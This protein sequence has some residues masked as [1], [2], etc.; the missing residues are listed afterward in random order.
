MAEHKAIRSRRIKLPFQSVGK[1]DYIF[2]SY[3][4]NDKDRVYPILKELFEAGYNIWYDEGITIGEHYDEEI[5][6][7]IRNSVAVIYFVSEWS[8]ARPYIT[9]TELPV[10]RENTRR[11][12]LPLCLEDAVDEPEKIT[13]ILPRERYDSVCEIISRLEAL[14]VKNYGKRIAVPI[15][16]DVPLYWLEGHDLEPTGGTENAVFT[17][18]APYACLSFDARDLPACNPYAKE[19]YFAGYNVRSC[20]NENAQNIAAMIS[21]TECNA[22]MPFVTKNYIESGQLE[23]DYNTAKAAGKRLVA[24]YMEPGIV[25]SLPGSIADEFSSY[26]GLNEDELRA[27]DFLSKLETELETRGCCVLNENGKVERR[28]FALRDYLY[29]F[30]PDRRGIVLTKYKGAETDVVI[31]KSYYGFPSVKL[32][33]TFSHNSDVV[34]VR[35]PFTV[36]EIIDKAFGECRNLKDVYV[37]DSVT[38]ISLDSFG[39]E[40]T[41]RPVY[42]V[43]HCSKRSFAYY[44]A[45]RFSAYYYDLYDSRSDQY[46]NCIQELDI[47]IETDLGICADGMSTDN[48][49]APEYIFHKEADGGITLT[50]YLG[51]ESHVVVPEELEGFPVTGIGSMTFC[52]SSK[53]T[54]VTLPDSIKSIADYAFHGCSSLTSVKLPA[55]VT[56]IA[57]HG[58]WDCTGLI[59]VTIPGSVKSIGDYAFKGC[60]SLTSV[61]LP[62]GVTDIGD[63]AF[64]GCRSLSAVS[65]PESVTRIGKKAFSWCER[66]TSAVIPDSVTNIGEETF[67]WCKSLLSVTIPGSVTSIG[68]KV[69]AGCTDALTVLCPQNSEAWRYCRGKKIPH[70][71]KRGDSAIKIVRILILFAVLLLLGLILIRPSF[72]SF[73]FKKNM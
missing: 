4:H 3:G 61:R 35:V 5:I 57:D 31:K 26:Q 2:A 51:E 69:F 28:S 6:R 22:F 13:A 70:R 12:I 48:V 40:S 46:V 62:D 53:L 67:S 42:C 24:L 52:K 65:L 63:G 32:D 41:E 29:D 33:H 1:G 59:S 54:S 56:S 10:A 16:R 50:A 19:L 66:L 7:S 36:N 34:S 8:V 11:A 27:N 49:H 58:F 44:Y 9:E 17:E 72:L 73:L 37:P 43:V 14:G 47:K 39:Y 25:R 60:S 64:F 20:E 30:T 71:R 21:S 68:R 15:E 38:H 55:G 45:K 23:R 18:E